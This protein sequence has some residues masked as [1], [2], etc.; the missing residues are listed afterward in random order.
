[1]NIEF[2]VEVYVSPYYWKQKSK[3]QHIPIFR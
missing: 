2:I 1:M 3:L